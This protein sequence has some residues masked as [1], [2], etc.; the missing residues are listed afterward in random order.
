MR[1]VTILMSKP[2]NVTDKATGMFTSL[3]CLDFRY[4]RKMGVDR[5]WQ[6]SG[7]IL[8][9]YKEEMKRLL[10]SYLISVE[11]VKVKISDWWEL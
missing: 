4:F 11:T 7:L 5:L 1:A 10:L 8:K 6:V 3:G 9:K 2:V